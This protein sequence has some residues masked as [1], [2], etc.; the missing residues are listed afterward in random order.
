MLD[1]TETL[2]AKSDQI[3]A[4]DFAGRPA[5]VTVEGAT[6][7]TPEQPLNVHLREFPG[8]AFRPAKTVRRIL[9]AAWGP[10]AEQWAGRR[11]TLYT[12]PDVTFGK[13]KTGGIRV[14]HMSGIERRMSIPLT[15]RRGK[16]QA[17]T[18]DP[19]PDAAPSVEVQ[20]DWQ[21]LIADAGDDVAALRAMWSDAQARGASEA[22][23]TDI[24]NAATTAQNKEN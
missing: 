13:E 22:I 20:P 8:R 21:A 16:K 1:I 2:A 3:N 19:L 23:L 9:A 4:D 5:T 15:V 7:G 24:K 18:I 6:R 10:D 14:S 12:D 11:M 17:Y